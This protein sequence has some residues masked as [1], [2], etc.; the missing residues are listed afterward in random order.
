[1]KSKYALFVIKKKKIYSLYFI[2]TKQLEYLNSA[3]DNYG[4]YCAAFVQP[5]GLTNFSII[6][7]DIL[8]IYMA[9]KVTT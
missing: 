2:K 1:M 8:N 6:I 5:E 3:H 7:A 9:I 4:K